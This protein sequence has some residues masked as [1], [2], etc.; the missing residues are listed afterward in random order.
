MLPSMDM[1][2]LIHTSSDGLINFLLFHFFTNVGL[3]K[4]FGVSA[5]ST[6]QIR[7]CSPLDIVIFHQ[8]DLGEYL[9]SEDIYL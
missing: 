2:C 1:K 4:G 3:K 6:M 9:R 5:K 7:A 8:A